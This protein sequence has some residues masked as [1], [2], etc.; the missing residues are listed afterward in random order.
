MPARGARRG[1]HPPDVGAVYSGL[2]WDSLCGV[3]RR[4]ANRIIRELVLARIAQPLSKRATV[5]GLDAHAALPLNLDS[6]H[7]AMDN[8]D[9]TKTDGI[10]ESSM[11]AAET[12]L[13]D[14]LTAVFH[15]TTTLYLESGDGDDLRVKDG[16]PHRI[17]VLFALPVTPEGLPVGYGLFPG[18]THEGGT[19][20]RAI[21][22][23]ET[24]YPGISL[25]LVADA[26]MIGRENEEALRRRGAPRIPGAR[27]K[28]RKAAGKRRILDLDRYLP[29]ERREFRKSIA[30]IR[31]IGTDGGWPI[32]THSPKR[33]RRD[34]RDR[35]RRIREPR[36]RLAKSGTAAGRCGRGP[37]S[38]P[39]SPEGMS[40]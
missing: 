17:Q 29:W 25:T 19:L 34:A 15:H 40:G 7:R 9:G 12:L 27:L 36:G 24:R 26:G 20:V 38:S 6:V 16:R 8:P 22:G 32:A 35:E 1:R 31:E 5:G 18:N 10:R 23:L 2:G 33:A 3:R 21:E 39:A 37:R 13:P 4:S 28:M 30:G 14:P 11:K